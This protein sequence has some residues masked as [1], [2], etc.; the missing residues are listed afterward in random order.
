MEDNEVDVDYYCTLDSGPI[1]IK[2]VAEGGKRTA[3]E[4]WEL[5]RERTLIA[6]IGSHPELLE[7]WQGKIYF[8]N[9]PLPSKDLMEKIDEIEV[10]RAFMSSGGNVLGSC[11][12]F[13]KAVL[14]C[15][16]IAYVGAD[17]SFGYDEKFHSWDSDYDKSLGRYV[18]AVD[19]YGLPVK[20]WQ[21][22]ANFKSWFDYIAETVP[23]IYINCTEGGCLGAYQG[24]NIR[25]IRQLRLMEFLQMYNLNHHIADPMNNPS[26]EMKKVLF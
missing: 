4:Y 1:T 7:K 14:G 23:G 12:Y 18:K 6:Y 10:F 16:P 11:L 22:Y 19:I 13:A 20:T 25:S 26:S 2:E 15:N 21:S 9:A 24:V 8:F 5:T 17:F 3:K